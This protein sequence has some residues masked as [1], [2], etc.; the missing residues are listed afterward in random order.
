MF[1]EGIITFNNICQAGRWVKIAKKCLLNPVFASR[2][3]L[4]FKYTFLLSIS[5]TCSTNI[6]VLLVFLSRR[7]MMT[8]LGLATIR[9]KK[10]FICVIII[11]VLTASLPNQ[12]VLFGSP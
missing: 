11:S 2:C 8:D 6:F 12:F 9:P 10:H 4:N 7:C 1:Y 5:C 3:F